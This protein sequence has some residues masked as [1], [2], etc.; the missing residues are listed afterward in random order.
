MK[1]ERWKST[2]S[3]F[4]FG[5]FSV[6]KHLAGPKRKYIFFCY[7]PHLICSTAH[8]KTN[9]IITSICFKFGVLSGNF[10]FSSL[11]FFLWPV[12]HEQLIRKFV[13]FDSFVH[14]KP[15]YQSHW[16]YATHACSLHFEW[17][18]KKINKSENCVNELGEYT[19]IV[20]TFFHHFTIQHMKNKM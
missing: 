7:F 1:N 14:K 15:V 20:R 6:H 12:N 16:S 5:N 8:G 13:T 9:S 2:I 18:G 17:N 19:F 11:S 10:G 3:R 4:E